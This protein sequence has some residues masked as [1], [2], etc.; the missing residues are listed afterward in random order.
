MSQQRITRRLPQRFVHAGKP[1]QVN[2]ADHQTLLGGFWNGKK[3][4]NL[5]H[6]QATVGQT[7]QFVVE[8]QVID[9]GLRAA[10]VGHVLERTEHTHG[11]QGI[12]V[13]RPFASHG[14]DALAGGRVVVQPELH[15]KLATRLAHGKEGLTHAGTI[16]GVHHRQQVSQRRGELCLPAEQ[17]VGVIGPFQQV[18]LGRP[19]PKPQARNAL[20]GRLALAHTAQ[21]AVELTAAQGVAHT[22][23][24]QGKVDG[25]G[26]E[27]GGTSG[28]STLDRFEVLTA[29]QHDD[30]RGMPIKLANQGTGL[31]PVHARHLH[32]HQNKVGPVGNERVHTILARGCQQHLIAML[33]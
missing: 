20:G 19:H 10:G 12:V 27:I 29:G 2:P 16:A 6:E 23:R 25:F 8:R 22:L 15:V 33:A 17:G 4:S 1:R 26:D 21:L 32:V 11:L 30:G 7:G 13:F 9:H 24:K 31:K 3:I 28:K 5:P 14:D 18:G